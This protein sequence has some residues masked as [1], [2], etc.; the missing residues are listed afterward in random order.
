M[1]GELSSEI[2]K[3]SHY[4]MSKAT[5]WCFTK[6]NYT[7]VDLVLLRDELAVK[8]LIYGKEVGEQGTPHLQGYFELP[9]NSPVVFAGIKA[10]FERIGL[11]G[12][13]IER[14]KGNATQNI[15]YCSKDNDIFEK[16]ERPKGQGKRTDLD[17]CC[18]AINEGKV[19]AD[20]IADF[21]SQVV[22]FQRGL[23]FLIQASSPRRSWKT[24]VYW[25]HGPSGS[26]KSRYAWHTSPGAYMKCSSHKWWTG[27]IGQD[28]VIIDDY[29][30]CKEMPFNFMLNL[31][32]RYPLS[33][34]TKGG[35]VEFL[36]KTV[37]ITSPYSP[38]TACNHL[39]WLG[40]EEKNQFLRRI[41]HVIEFPQLAM[42]FMTE[43]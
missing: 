2:P 29:R 32:D 31:L 17:L 8:Y 12:Y 40:T 7:D 26:G 42:M 6:N 25:L 13:H 21:P 11:M 4:F 16:G 15:A 39:E 1:L 10:R 35:M 9:N 14:A 41:E 3:K 22:K 34:E 36:A 27:Y 20:L 43:T 30:P 38:E 33:V 18:E 5:R 24:E 37:Y 23:E 28:S 19:M